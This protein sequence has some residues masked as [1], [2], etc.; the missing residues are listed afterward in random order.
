MLRKISTILLVVT[1]SSFAAT[2]Q[3][4]GIYKGFGGSVGGEYMF[5]GWKGSFAG[6]DP[7][8]AMITA[9]FQAFFLYVSIGYFV[10][11]TGYEVYGFNE[12]IGSQ[13]LKIGASLQYVAPG[14]NKFVF[15]PYVGFGSWGVWDTSGNAIGA[16]TSYAAREKF[17]SVGIKALYK[18]RDLPLSIGIDVS[19][20]TAGAAIGFLL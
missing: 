17:T 11:N 9:D 2:A 19:T 4:F 6:I 3:D 18:L 15:C 12:R 5:R 10:K 13:H 14:N 20:H 7:S 8:P 1:L 16:R